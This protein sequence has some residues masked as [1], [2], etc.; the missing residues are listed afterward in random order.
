M[1]QLMTC[2]KTG[3]GGDHARNAVQLPHFPFFS[4]VEGRGSIWG[5]V[6]GFLSGQMGIRNNSQWGGG[7][8]GEEWKKRE[9]GVEG[10]KKRRFT[11]RDVHI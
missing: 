4:S 2:Q 6:I 9:I 7:G 3:D 1:S 10:G 8:G 5:S 11:K